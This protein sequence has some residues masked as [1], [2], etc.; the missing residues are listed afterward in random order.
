MLSGGAAGAASLCFV[1]PLD[2]CRTRLAADIGKDNRQFN[3][4][5]DCL[6]KIY[7]SDGITGLYQGF[8]ISVIGIIAYR[9]VYFGCYD[10]GKM[11]LFED[12]KKAS[13][14]VKFIYAMVTHVYIFL[15]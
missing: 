15:Y 2:F 7:K 4:L 13:L 6:S 3:G 11:I 14:V 1:Y 9:A 10:A 12:E 5:V 8:N